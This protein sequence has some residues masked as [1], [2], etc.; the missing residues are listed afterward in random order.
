[1]LF[2]AQSAARRVV[3]GSSRP[4]R[5]RRQLDRENGG[6]R[7]SQ[8]AH[9]RS[10]SITDPATIRRWSAPIMI[11]SGSFAPSQ[12][13]GDRCAGRCSA[14]AGSSGHRERSNARGTLKPAK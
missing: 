7:C 2:A 5:A 8:I 9:D 14:V 4:P 6:E 10:I 12:R 3:A 11:I 1:M 13:R